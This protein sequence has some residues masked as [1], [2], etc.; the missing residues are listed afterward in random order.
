MT[1]PKTS[2]IRFR[3]GYANPASLLEELGRAVNRGE[4]VLPIGRT[5]PTGTRFLFEM[6]APGVTP[7]VEVLGEVVK[8]HPAEGGGFSLTVRYRRGH[9]RAGV[10]AALTRLREAHRFEK[11][12]AH[13]RLPFHLPVRE[14]AD[15]PEYR[16]R[17]L[18][19]GGY[20]IERV[21][22]GPLPPHIHAG[23]IALLEITLSEGI[24]AL[25]GEVTWALA[26]GGAFGGTQPGFG[27]R[28]G[29]LSPANDALL[30]RV[31]S[32]ELVP[33]P[34]PPPRLSFGA[35]AVKRMP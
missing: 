5:V 23:E 17:D 32:L 28:L 25:H 15:G 26:R 3:L 18:S 4:V 19:L 8:V 2:P 27:V 9:G 13:A 21:S 33:Q 20:G 35:L 6:N 12:R 10:D 16:V 14:A 30:D 29:T 1:D 22:E 7:P 34:S 24:M 11:V 31:L